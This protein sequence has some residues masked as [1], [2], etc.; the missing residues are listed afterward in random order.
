MRKNKFG[1]VFS[2]EHPEIRNMF[3]AP[4]MFGGMG[5]L[6][7]MALRNCELGIFMNATM[8]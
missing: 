3:F 4:I 7:A 6:I 2:L 8:V 5:R 1:K